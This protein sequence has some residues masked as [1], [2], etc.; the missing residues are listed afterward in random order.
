MTKRLATSVKRTLTEQEFYEYYFQLRNLLIPK[1]ERLAN[2]EVELTA[3]L[4]TKDDDYVLDAKK[5]KNGRSKKY[6]LAETLGIAPTGIYKLL[7]N[8]EEKGILTKDEDDFVELVPTL[9]E[10]TKNIEVPLRMVY[11]IEIDIHEGD[12]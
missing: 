7:Q 12:N 5:S 4:C 10:V 2:K 6:E 11:N 1:D 3:L 9:K 8:L